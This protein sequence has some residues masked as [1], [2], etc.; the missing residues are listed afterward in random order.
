MAENQFQNIQDERDA[1][2]E[3]MR[4]LLKRWAKLHSLAPLP[5]EA[6]A[7]VEMEVFSICGRLQDLLLPWQTAHIA[8]LS[9]Y[10]EVQAVL[11][12]GGFTAHLD[13]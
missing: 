13:S 4:I 8:L 6:S 10:E 11:R 12:A 2:E 5:P 7:Q 1:L 3:R 9:A